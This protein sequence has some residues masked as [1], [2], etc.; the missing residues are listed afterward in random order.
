MAFQ[1]RIRVV[2]G[3]NAMVSGYRLAA[4]GKMEFSVAVTQTFKVIEDGAAEEVVNV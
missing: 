2:L 1:N 3:R 4:N